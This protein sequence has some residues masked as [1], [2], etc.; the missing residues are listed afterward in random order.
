MR[1]DAVHQR[2]P[3][4]ESAFFYPAKLEN[5]EDNIGKLPLHDEYNVRFGHSRATRG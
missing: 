1:I 4:C 3:S 5:E 2:R